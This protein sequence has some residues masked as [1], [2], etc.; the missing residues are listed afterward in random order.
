MSALRAWLR[1]LLAVGMLA[2]FYLLA[3]V[4]VLVYAA[5]V[6][7]AVSAMVTMPERA[8]SGWL[9]AVG[10]SI[11]AV[12]ALIHG[13]A[14]VSRVPDLPAGAVF[15]RRREAPGLWR[16]VDELADQ[17]GTRA[18]SRIY[19]TPDANAAVSEEAR[20]LGFAVGERTLY[21]GVPLLT[22]LTPAQ[23]RAVLGHEFGHYTGGHTRFGAITYRGAAA[24]DSALFRLGMT[25]RS[26]QGIPGYAWFLHFVIGIYARV[27]LRVSLAVRRR[28]ELEADARAAAMAGPA[29]TAEALRAV[30]AIG[31]AWTEF[32]DT[33][34]HP[35]RRIGFVPEDLF[36]AFDIMMD[37]LLV[38]ERMTELRAHPVDTERSRLDSHPPLARRLAR[39][40]ALPA[41]DPPTWTDEPLLADRAPL[42][43]VQQK[44][45][46][47]GSAQA[48]ALP[49][50]QWADVAAEAF[51]VEQAG[52]LVEAARRVGMT[53]HPTLDT[54]LD[55]L[56]QGRQLDLARRLT[57]EAEPKH[58]LAE[59]LH[60]LVGQALAAAGQARWVFSWT[61]GYL[62]VPRVETG[63]DLEEVVVAAAWSPAGAGE[64]RADLVRRGLRV[65]EP[66]TLA[67][68]SAPA[69][70]GQRRTRMDVSAELP[71]FVAEE[72]DR[73]R[74]VRNFTLG[75]LALLMLAWGVALVVPDEP[76][77]LGQVT[78][79]HPTSSWSA[80]RNLGLLPTPTL[81]PVPPLLQ[82]PYAKPSIP[83]P[84]WHAP[85]MPITVQRGDTL[86]RIACRYGTTVREL[87]ELNGLGTRTRIYAGQGLLVP[88]PFVRATEPR[89]CD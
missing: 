21:V 50:A 6:V 54:V 26:R 43:R 14:S 86:T 78:A 22:Q 73:Q 89:D 5:L 41:G 44:I 83:L 59:A 65:D 37:D 20:M 85:L 77:P 53:A 17:L 87:Q 64:L 4:L 58:R 13:V 49:W 48:T 33:F 8:G 82:P 52:R 74:V 40:E 34:V 63:R 1:G 45:L 27:F 80:P 55:L 30:H 75:V 25:E 24:L 57:G 19:L 72:I 32:L 36:G 46:G 35:V 47:E 11:P 76:R 9:F 67:V 31:H 16:L 79:A 81:D 28:Q 7:G 12:L 3:C 84:S 29:V 39:I 60:A 51:A 69:P 56:E 23:L 42:R 2:G 38:Q 62:L 61:K 68:Q 10:G 70:A 15:V 88:A 66:V 71:P 18:P